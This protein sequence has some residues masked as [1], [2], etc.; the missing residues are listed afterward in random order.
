MKLQLF[1][2]LAFG[3]FSLFVSFTP[4][5]AAGT[6][7]D[8]STYGP[9]PG[10][11][12]A[13]LADGGLVTFACS[14]TII[15]PGIGIY[16]DTTI[17]A[18]G[19][20]V[21]LSGNNA[22]PIFSVSTPFD[23]EYPE[24]TDLTL[25]NLTLADG[26]STGNGGA[27][28]VS[29]ASVNLQNSTIRDSHSDGVGG[30]VAIGN[31]DLEDFG[32]ISIVDSVITGNTADGGG[33]VNANPG[34]ISVVRSVI[35]NNAVTFYGGAFVV[36]G[37]ITIEDSTFIGNEANHGGVLYS[38]S[39]WGGGGVSITN[40]TFNGNRAVGEN[41]RGGVIYL[42]GGEESMNLRFSTF[43][44]N[45]AATGGVLY[46]EGSAATV[47]NSLFAANTGGD[48]EGPVSTLNNLADDSCG[49]TAPT[50]VD[51]NLQDNGGPTPTHALLEGSNA[52]DAAL[53]CPPPYTDQRGQTRPADGNGD[54]VEVCDIGAYETGIS[55][56]TPLRNIYTDYVFDLTWGGVSWA[57]AYEVQI[58][59]TPDFSDVVYTEITSSTSIT[60]Y[61]G[62]MYLE[63]GPHYWRVRAQREDETW[64]EWSRADSFVV[65]RP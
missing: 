1:F 19:Q 24:S 8:C 14:G 48:C 35:A 50:G 11:L 65:A 17:D 44:G 40:S 9:G 12:E 55:S 30:A 2:L 32:G 10:T 38:L 42:G 13:A 15:V 6:V 21:T 4:V 59:R 43:Y 52:I 61:S 33:A 26:Y 45:S 28:W 18:T 41:S 57:D 31:G 7:T 29:A 25:I 39:F 3:W 49:T 56:G 16:E 23:V 46:T 51:P 37:G 64:D 53:R 60:I 63:N 54:G 27:I 22:N 62:I 34:G 36:D 58:S 20:D 47:Q 5:H